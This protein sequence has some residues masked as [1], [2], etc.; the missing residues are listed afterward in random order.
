MMGE[1]E[2]PAVAKATPYKIYSEAESRI[3]GAK[4]TGGRLDYPRGGGPG[5]TSHQIT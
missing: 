3:C 5:I 1:K 4:V 2:T